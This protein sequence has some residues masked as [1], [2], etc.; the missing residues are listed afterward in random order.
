MTW[1]RLA[2]LAILSLGLASPP[3]SAGEPSPPI[4]GP[5]IPA[6]LKPGDAFGEPVELPQRTIIYVEGSA[7]WDAAFD[8]LIKAYK[9]LNE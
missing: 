5:D 8:T 2:A 1:R 3:V 7:P 4:A 6:P 9:S